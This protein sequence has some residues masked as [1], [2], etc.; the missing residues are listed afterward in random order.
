VR[1]REVHSGAAHHQR[2]L[3]VAPDHA[4]DDLV[5]RAVAADDDEQPCAAVDRASRK[6][7]QVSGRIGE[8]RVADKALRG[9]RVRDLR[10][11]LARRA[12]RRRGVDEED[13]V[14]NERL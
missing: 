13:C 5:E 3:D 4:V 7:R 9:R 10:P 6:L 1:A 2:E 11:A 12:V 14:A 8:E